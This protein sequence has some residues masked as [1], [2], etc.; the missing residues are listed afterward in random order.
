MKHLS[1]KAARELRRWTQADLERVSGVS[2]GTISKLERGD[3][4][5]PSKSTAD[6][7]D[8]AFKFQRGT[9][10]FGR[11]AEALAS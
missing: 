7:L 6:A 9:L 11:D 10:V 2:Q 8:D 3:I 1:L 4:V 5:D